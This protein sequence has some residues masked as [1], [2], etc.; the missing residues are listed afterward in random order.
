MLV[1]MIKLE[2]GTSVRTLLHA[3]GL[4][5]RQWNTDPS[6]L[7][8]CFCIVVEYKYKSLKPLCIFE[9]NSEYILFVSNCSM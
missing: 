3:M 4:T 1:I 7:F 2:T 6:R 8:I 5:C 9:D